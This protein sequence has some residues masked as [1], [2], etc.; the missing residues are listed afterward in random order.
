MEAVFQE[1]IGKLYDLENLVLGVA[2][3]E[4]EKASPIVT[5]ENSKKNIL[6][7]KQMKP[8]RSLMGRE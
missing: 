5:L 7:Q 8:I 2:V 1:K 3:Q 4:N 6:F